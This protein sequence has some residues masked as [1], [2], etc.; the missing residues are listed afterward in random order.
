MNM[1]NDCYMVYHSQN[2]FYHGKTFDCH[3][4]TMVVA[5][6]MNTVRIYSGSIVTA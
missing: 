4:I 6:K 3:E 2:M 1:I 5:R